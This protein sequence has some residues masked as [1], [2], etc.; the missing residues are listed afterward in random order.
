LSLPFLYQVHA[1]PTGSEYVEILERLA[2]SG[3]G[4]TSGQSVSVGGVPGTF[5]KEGAVS[6]VEFRRRGIDTTV[7]TSLDEAEAL[8]IAA[9]L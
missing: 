8:K 7:R 5:R 2:A 3:H 4:L 6:V 9:S 1:N